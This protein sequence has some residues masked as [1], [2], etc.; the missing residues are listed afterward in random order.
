MGKIFDHKDLQT[1][2][3]SRSLLALSLAA[4]L[5]A[6]GCTTNLNL[7]NGAPS[8]SGSEIRTAPTSGVSSG[9]ESAPVLPPPM[10]SSSTRA[11]ATS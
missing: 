5:A 11:E 4:S 10:T 1:R 3:T 8:R 9:S 2:R 6:F 7:G